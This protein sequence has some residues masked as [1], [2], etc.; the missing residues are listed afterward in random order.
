MGRWVAVGL[1]AK[2]GW[3]A[4]RRIWR[5]ATTRNG[6]LAVEVAGSKVPTPYGPMILPKCAC[7]NARR[8]GNPRLLTSA[9]AGAMR[10]A[11]S[12]HQCASLVAFVVAHASVFVFF[13][14]HFCTQ[15]RAVPALAPKSKARQKP[16]HGVR[17]RPRKSKGCSRHAV[18]E[19]PQAGDD[20][21]ILGCWR[22]GPRMNV[23]PN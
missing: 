5:E 22:H 4:G 20:A 6:Y 19:R 10:R 3:T 16:P 13:I 18:G 8:L 2:H 9:R 11:T 23:V 1:C 21:S 17:P 14:G 15:L 12:S 7:A